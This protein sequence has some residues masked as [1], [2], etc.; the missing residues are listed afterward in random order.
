MESDG[1]P[2]KSRTLTCLL[3]AVEE[4]SSVRLVE[5]EAAG[6]T[7]RCLPLDWVASAAGE[8]ERRGRQISVRILSPILRAS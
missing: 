8:A 4:G 7:A 6:L 2:R 5:E 1:A 3:G